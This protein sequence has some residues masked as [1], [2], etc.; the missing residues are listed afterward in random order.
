MQSH[1]AKLFISQIH[2]VNWCKG[3]QYDIML[4]TTKIYNLGDT[5]SK[6]C[7]FLAIKQLRKVGAWI[8]SKFIINKI[9]KSPTKCVD[10]KGSKAANV[11]YRL[12]KVRLHNSWRWLP[13]KLLSQVSTNLVL[14]SLFVSVSKT[15]N[16]LG[17]VWINYMRPELIMLKTTKYDQKQT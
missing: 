15:M 12:R 10:K 2:V 14:Q 6:L 4:Q 9:H 11:H 17:T 3:C 13:L 7:F 5:V 16:M 1:T 8:L